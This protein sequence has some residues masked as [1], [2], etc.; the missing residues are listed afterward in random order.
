M[1][2]N[3]I[4]DAEDELYSLISQ[5][6]YGDVSDIDVYWHGLSSAILK[7]KIEN[8]KK[9]KLERNEVMKVSSVLEGLP[10]QG[11][12]P[13]VQI[14]KKMEK[15]SEGGSNGNISEENLDQLQSLA[16]D[17]EELFEELLMKVKGSD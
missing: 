9:P 8:W 17:F 1:S 12:S 10:I 6:D 7:L 2:K 4:K 15:L 11:L 16:V 14:A 3:K 5:I 13:L